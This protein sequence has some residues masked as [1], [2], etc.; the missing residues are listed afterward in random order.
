MPIGL[1]PPLPPP[2]SLFFLNLLL[3]IPKINKPKFETKHV[4]I[5]V[6]DNLLKQ[7]EKSKKTVMSH[8]LISLFPQVTN[9]IN[10]KKTDKNLT[11]EIFI[12]NLD[13][14]AELL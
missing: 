10:E 5:S 7:E 14:I 6:I 1:P 12:P 13:K 9:I 2:A 3:Y 4:T 8:K 11:N